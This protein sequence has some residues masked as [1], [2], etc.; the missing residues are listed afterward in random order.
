[1]LAGGLTPDNVALAI[2][3]VRIYGVDVSG[4]V[5]STPSKKDGHKICTFIRNAKNT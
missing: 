3:S 4:G 2:S 5:E 1:M